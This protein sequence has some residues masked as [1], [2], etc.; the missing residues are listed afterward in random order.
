MTQFN[1]KKKNTCFGCINLTNKWYADGSS[2]YGCS[3][4]PGLVRG[5][6]SGSEDGYDP[7]RCENYKETN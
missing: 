7:E 1:E 2:Y 4:I 6:F 3:L 5:V